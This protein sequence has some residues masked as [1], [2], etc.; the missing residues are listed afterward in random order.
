MS[1]RLLSKLTIAPRGAV[2]PVIL[3]GVSHDSEHAL[4]APAVHAR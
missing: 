2:A 4:R 3:R 1:A